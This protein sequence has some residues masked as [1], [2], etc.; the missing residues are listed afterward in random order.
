MKSESL[1]ARSMDFGASHGFLSWMGMGVLSFAPFDAIG[2][3]LRGTK[4]VMMDMFR[5]EDKLFKAINIMTDILIHSVL[6]N[7]I[8]YNAVTVGFPLHKGADG[9][10]SPKM[11]PFPLQLPISQPEHLAEWG[12]NMQLLMRINEELQ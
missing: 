10:M 6:H 3:T 9:W 5:N 7:P 4:S 11:H 12:R 8:I 2:D 1:S